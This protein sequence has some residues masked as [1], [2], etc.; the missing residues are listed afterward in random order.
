LVGGERLRGV[1]SG[2]L[3]HLTVMHHLRGL[4]RRGVLLRLRVELNL[5]FHMVV[6][7]LVMRFGA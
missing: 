3:E 1:V 2:A 4:G 5:L 6:A 7:G